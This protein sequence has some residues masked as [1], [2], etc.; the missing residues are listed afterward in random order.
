MGDPYC[1]ERVFF[2]NFRSVEQCERRHEIVLSR[3]MKSS[4]DYGTV[5]VMHECIEAEKFEGAGS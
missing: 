5:Y 4:E 2:D 3:L 1:E